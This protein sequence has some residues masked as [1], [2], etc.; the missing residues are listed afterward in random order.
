[1]VIGFAYFNLRTTIA[2]K[3]MEGLRQKKSM[4]LSDF[5]LEYAMVKMEDR[6]GVIVKQYYYN[7]SFSF[8]FMVFFSL[9]GN[10]KTSRLVLYKFG[11]SF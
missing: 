2:R 7:V 9:I 6:N 8:D 11:S 1:M 10:F 5:L 3:K 4:I